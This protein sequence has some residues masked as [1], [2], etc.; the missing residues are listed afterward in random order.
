MG[1]DS[2]IVTI[3]LLVIQGMHSL[4]MT[5]GVLHSI[6]SL[7]IDSAFKNECSLHHTIH[8]NNYYFTGQME[9]TLAISIEEVDITLAVD[10]E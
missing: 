7:I 10:E 3:M 9:G 8:K 1:E 5:T 2:S 4:E 6:I